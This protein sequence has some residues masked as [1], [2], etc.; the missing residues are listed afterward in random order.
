MLVKSAAVW[1]DGS[2]VPAYRLGYTGGTGTFAA[3]N[4]VN[5]EYVEIRKAV[6]IYCI[7]YKE[8]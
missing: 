8:Y 1:R 3:C 6:P 4:F 7:F 2:R 5:T